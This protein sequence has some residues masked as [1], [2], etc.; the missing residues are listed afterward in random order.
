MSL[1]Y[2]Q[3]KSQEKAQQ[4]L[5]GALPEF[6]QSGYDGT[7]MDRVA[8]AAGVSKQTVYSHFGDKEGLFKALVEQVARHKFQLVWAKPLKGKPEK[9]LK[10]LAFRLLKE[11]NNKEQLLFAHLLITESRKH[12]ELSQLFL[13]NVTKPAIVVLSNY[14]KE[15]SQLSVQNPEAIAH[16]FVNTLIHHVL[17]QEMLNAKEIMPMSQSVLIDNLINLIVS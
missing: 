7:S 2:H 13:A 6:L 4:I 17:T 10:E 15:T 1:S 5:K 8:Q 12:P 9:V 11:V 3:Q 16:I 14:F